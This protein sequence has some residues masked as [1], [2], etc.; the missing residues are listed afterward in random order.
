MA[1]KVSSLSPDVRGQ[2]ELAPFATRLVDSQQAPAIGQNQVTFWGDSKTGKCAILM[3]VGNRT[4]RFFGTEVATGGGTA[5]NPSSPTVPE[6]PPYA[7][8]SSLSAFVSVEPDTVD[9][10]RVTAT[11]VKALILDSDGAQ[12]LQEWQVNRETV[13]YIGPDGRMFTL[14]GIDAGGAPVTNIPWPVDPSDA[15]NL[16]FLLTDF[17]EVVTAL[18]TPSE[19]YDRRQVCLR[20]SGYPDIVY[21]CLQLSDGNW[22]WCVSEGA[23]Y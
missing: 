22:E 5:G 20:V 8:T 10:N 18:P 4:F 21:R 2:E 13:A 12:N 14:R 9:R 17:V 11:G 19:D 6:T 3:R 7:E 16:E 15:V 1:K 23:S